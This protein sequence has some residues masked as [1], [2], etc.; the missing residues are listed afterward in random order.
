MYCCTAVLLH[1]CRKFLERKVEG[2]SVLRL[3]PGLYFDGDTGAGNDGGEGGKLV[4]VK[5]EGLAAT[6]KVLSV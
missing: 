2:P 4:N 6:L 1:C 3:W 5:G